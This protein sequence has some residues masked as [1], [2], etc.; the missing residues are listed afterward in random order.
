MNI[1][2]EII[3]AIVVALLVSWLIYVRLDPIAKQIATI[4]RIEGKLDLLLK[5]AGIEYNPYKNVSP[6]VVDFLKRG[7]KIEAIKCYRE[8]N[9]GVGLK[10]AKEFVEEVQRRGGLA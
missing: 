10:D 4:S 3:A 2:P 6:R 9:A 5:H 8:E 7:K 1:S